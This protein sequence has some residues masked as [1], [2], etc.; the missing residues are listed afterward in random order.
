MVRSALKAPDLKLGSS[1]GRALGSGSG[2]ISS[3]IKGGWGKLWGQ[4]AHGHDRVMTRKIGERFGR[5][6]S[7]LTGGSFDQKVD[8]KD[9]TRSMRN[10]FS[11]GTKQ[12]AETVEDQHED[13][14]IA[15][16]QRQEVRSEGNIVVNP[17]AV[18]PPAVDPPD[19]NNERGS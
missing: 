17:P 12:S 6:A 8:N 9:G 7:G 18:D 16:K 10:M 3:P 19:T 4:D 5:I 1:I 11:R 15:A 13:A 2:F 14:K